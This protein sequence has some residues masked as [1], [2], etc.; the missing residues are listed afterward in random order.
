M[1]KPLLRILPWALPALPWSAN[2]TEYRHA[3]DLTSRLAQTRAPVLAH[4][5]VIQA[6]ALLS[7]HQLRLASQGFR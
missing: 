2:W 7:R 5:A 3:R 1:N 4:Q 6:R